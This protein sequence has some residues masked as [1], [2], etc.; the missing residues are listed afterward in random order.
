MLS[1]DNF[2][3]WY[4]VVKKVLRGPVLEASVN[5]QSEL[6]QNSLRRLRSSQLQISMQV[7]E[8][9]VDQTSWYHCAAA[10]RTRC[11]LSKTI[12]GVPTRA[13]YSSSP[14][15]KLAS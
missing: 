13:I 10:F 6:T 8:K 9:V 5:S 2:T 3:E 14:Y 4:A 1:T 7:A 11:S 15:M 12:F